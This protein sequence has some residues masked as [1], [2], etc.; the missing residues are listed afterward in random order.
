MG[1]LKAKD[2]ITT[3]INTGADASLNLFQA[4]LSLRNTELNTEL[5]SSLLSFR[6]TSLPQTPS[7]DVV[8]QELPYM[9]TS[10]SIPV[11]GSTLKRASSFTIRVDENY[12]VYSSLRELQCVNDDGVFTLDKN[13]RFNLKIEAMR[14]TQDTS[15]IYDYCT[16]YEWDF[17]ECYITTVSA[18]AY[19]YDSSSQATSTVGFI[20]RDYN[21]FPVQ[22]DS[23]VARV[24]PQGLIQGGI[25]DLRDLTQL[26]VNALFGYEE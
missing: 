23:S 16:V 12:K 7:R 5:N 10:I 17:S 11:F 14:P 3:L 6:I 20:Y 21:E 4:T 9:G 15:S 24:T 13:K 8:T 1:S 18:L 26:G 22:G 2:F 25:S 19:N